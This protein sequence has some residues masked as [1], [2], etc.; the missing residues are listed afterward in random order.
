M[1]RREPRKTIP[2]INNQASD[3]VVVDGVCTSEDLVQ[4]GTLSG[5]ATIEQLKKMYPKSIEK[6]TFEMEKI[7]DDRFNKLLRTESQKNKEKIDTIYSNQLI[8]NKIMETRNEIININEQLKK[9]REN[10]LIYQKDAKIRELE[11]IIKEQQLKR[12]K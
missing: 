4:M 6:E 1:K 12:D 2:L 7:L 3:K 10:N 11:K 5:Q 8:K 9:T